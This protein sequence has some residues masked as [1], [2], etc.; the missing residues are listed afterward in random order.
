MIRTKDLHCLFEDLLEL[1]INGTGGA[2]IIDVGIKIKA[3]IEKHGQGIDSS[4]VEEQS[5]LVEG[6]VVEESPPIHG[7]DGNTGHIGVAQNVI[8][9]IESKNASEELL[10]QEEPLRMF[11]IFFLEWSLDEERYVLRVD[12]FPLFEATVRTLPNSLHDGRN[13]FPDDVLADLL[14]VRFESRKILF[15]EEMAE[16]TVPDVMEEASEPEEFF[17]VEWRRKL[18]PKDA[19]QRGIELF[20]KDT[21]Y[22]H[23]PER[24]L[25]TGMFCRGKNPT[26]TLKLEDTPKSLDPG[27]INN[28]PLG[29]LPFHTIG[30]HDVMVNG[31]RNQPGDLI[32][33]GS[34]HF[35]KPVLGFIGWRFL[36]FLLIP[37]VDEFHLCR[38]HF[39]KGVH[40][41]PVIG[42]HQR[43]GSPH[44]HLGPSRSQ[45]NQRKTTLHLFQT[46][47]HRNS[48]HEVPPIV[49]FFVQEERSSFCDNAPR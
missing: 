33:S 36:L 30:H 13:F 4:L 22:M 6:G 49:S 35:L 17:N 45:D 44:D 19:G 23:R 47:F 18:I 48:S 46:I 1:K 5:F 7:T 39:S 14:M 32:L 15:V 27:S 40:N 37:R 2:V 41:R 28:V 3:S 24:V 10:E 16:G 25:K 29:P 43:G 12:G 20:R 11:S 26:G 34:L 38:S 42:L 21:R 9:I 8:D 31:V